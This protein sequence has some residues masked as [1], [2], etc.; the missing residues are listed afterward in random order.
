[1]QEAPT[2]R[3]INVTSSAHAGAKLPIQWILTQADY[4]RRRAY[5]Q[6]KLA[7]VLFTRELARRLAPMGVAAYAVHPGIAITGFARN[8]GLQSWLRHLIAHALRRE[9]ITA[10][11]GAHALTFLA[12][13]VDAGPSGAYYHGCR[14]ATPSHN[15][16]NPNL[17][18]DLWSASLRLCDQ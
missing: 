7:N 9:L 3:I 5:A 16:Q 13:S 14:S 17:A 1:M 18:E 11:R 2:A 10:R 12:T 8:N 6:S 4:D 15:A